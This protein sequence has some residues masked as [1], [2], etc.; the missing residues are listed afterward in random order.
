M[1]QDVKIPY[2]EAVMEVQKA[3]DEG[4]SW[5]FIVASDMGYT[6]MANCVPFYK[7]AKDSQ[8]RVFSFKKD[9]EPRFY[10]ALLSKKFMT[11][12]DMCVSGM[13]TTNDDSTCD[14][15][16]PMDTP[17]EVFYWFT[18]TFRLEQLSRN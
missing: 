10:I 2:Q 4:R 13:A 14:V 1:D 6:A 15:I 12:S 7:D 8:R 16:I 3:L 9:D 5:V 18:E 17:R 11:K